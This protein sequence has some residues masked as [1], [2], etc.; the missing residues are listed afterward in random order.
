MH[1]ADVDW[2]ATAPTLRVRQA[3]IYQPPE[4]G[5]RGHYLMQAYTKKNDIRVTPLAGFAVAILARR[6]Q[7]A[8][9]EG[10]LFHTGGAEPSR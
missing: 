6:S 7:N 2:T 5:K 1:G 8:T 9:A 10:L 3:V 4:G